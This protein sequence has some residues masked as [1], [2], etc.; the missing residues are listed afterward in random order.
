[1]DTRVVWPGEFPVQVLGGVTACLA[2]VVWFGGVGCAFADDK[3]NGEQA[4]HAL[5]FGGFDLWRHNGFLHGGVLWSPDGLDREGFTLKVLFAGGRYRYPSGT[6]EIVGQEMLGGL[7]PGWRFKSDRVEATFFVGG[8]LQHHQLTPDDPGARLRGTRAGLR[9]AAD[10]WYQPSDMMMLTASVSAATT[11]SNLWGRA[12][13]GWRVLD[14][15]WAGPEVEAFG[16]HR[17]QEL[18][19]GLHMTALKTGALEWS[20]GFGYARDTDDRAGLYGRVG[21]LTRR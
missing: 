18:R 4:A 21:L 14:R 9:A 12:A 5:L 8:D 16:D 6:R 19:I 3:A 20:A 2:A 10:L 11:G 17:Y 13:A 7:L 1:L 15:F